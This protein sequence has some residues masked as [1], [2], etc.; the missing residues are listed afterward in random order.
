MRTC[1]ASVDNAW[2]FVCC[3]FFVFTYCTVVYFN[4]SHCCGNGVVWCILC[5]Y[6]K[7][8]TNSPRVLIKVRV[9]THLENLEYSQGIKEWSGKKGKVRENVFL[10]VAIYRAYCFWHKMCKKGLHSAYRLVLH[11]YKQKL[12]HW[13]IV[14]N[15]VVIVMTVYMS[16][17]VR[18]NMHF[19]LYRYCCEGW[20][21]VN[22]DLKCLEKSGNLIMTGEWP[23]WKCWANLQTV[24][25]S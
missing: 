11:F 25:S 21:S 15:T 20:Y 19:V 5:L 14:K 24:L 3:H 18:N 2:W 7:Q 16:T 12:S 10:H 8:D 13:S 23:P 9:A 22:F 6:V 4:S 17:A 1:A